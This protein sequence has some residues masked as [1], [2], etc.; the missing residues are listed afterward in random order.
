MFLI[1]DDIG[2]PKVKDNPYYMKARSIAVPTVED[3]L[4]IPFSDIWMNDKKINAD[5]YQHLRPSGEKYDAEIIFT[6]RQGRDFIFGFLITYKKWEAFDIVEDE[7]D[8]DTRTLVLD[9]EGS[10]IDV[11]AII[12]MIQT[13]TSWIVDA[14]K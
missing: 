7:F 5:I 11:T 8:F 3:E 13:L 10:L 14:E 6:P 2:F 9:A 1:D 4:K 12:D